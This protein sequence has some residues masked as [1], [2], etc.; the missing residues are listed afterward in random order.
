MADPPGETLQQDA[1]PES[2]AAL[3]GSQRRRFSR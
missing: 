3:I 2:A 1:D